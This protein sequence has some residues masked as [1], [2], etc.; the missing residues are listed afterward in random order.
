[1]RTRTLFHLVSRFSLSYRTSLPVGHLL[2]LPLRPSPIEL[3]D[4]PPLSAPAPNYP[5][6]RLS[7]W[8]EFQSLIGFTYCD[9]FEASSDRLSVR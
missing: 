2:A 9:Y 3:Q 1:M 6:Y 8:D 4:I 7:D 5:L